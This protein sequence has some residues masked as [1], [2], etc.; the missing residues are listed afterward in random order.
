MPAPRGSQLRRGRGGPGAVAA[1]SGRIPR[2]PSA[3]AR[4]DALILGWQSEAL[5]AFPGRR[6]V[7]D[8]LSGASLHSNPAG[9]WLESVTAPGDALP[10]VVISYLGRLRVLVT[11]RGERYL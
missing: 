5:P 2:A 10:A 4:S 6:L 8:P 1:E 11:Q 9:V 7:G 3:R